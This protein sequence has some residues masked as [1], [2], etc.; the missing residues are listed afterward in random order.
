MTGES[1]SYVIQAIS[2]YFATVLS[3][4]FQI[5]YILL[6]IKWCLVF[7]T[8]L[9][10]I[11]TDVI[12]Y[13]PGKSSMLPIQRSYYFAYVIIIYYCIPVIIIYVIYI[14]I[15]YQVKRTK[16]RART[17]HNSEYRQ[18]RD[19]E[20]LRKILILT[21]VY[22]GTGLPIVLFY[23]V[24]T[25]YPYLATLLAMSLAVIFAKCFTIILR[26]IYSSYAYKK[27]LWRNNR[28]L[29]EL[30]ILFYDSS[31]HVAILNNRSRLKVLSSVIKLLFS[32]S[33]IC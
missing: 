32:S 3:N 9:S 27:I 15:F 26:S 2:R 25:K 14:C 20:L 11:L 30:Y 1:Y 8:T 5:H 21:T 6:G 18:R 29:I 13:R 7:V 19:F 10:I 23:F 16:Q 28:T 12:R 4:K 17:L 31:Q 24:R 22:L 33:K